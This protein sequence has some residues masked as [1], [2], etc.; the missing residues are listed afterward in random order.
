MEANFKYMRSISCN[1]IHNF[2][3]DFHI[4]HIFQLL[5][6]IGFMYNLLYI[7]LFYLQSYILQNIV[8]KFWSYHI[9]GILGCILGTRIGSL[10]SILGTLCMKLYIFVSLLYIIFTKQPHLYNRNYIRF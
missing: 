2:C 6:I 4:L 5:G 10:S 8:C 1:F 9:L 7:N 3:M